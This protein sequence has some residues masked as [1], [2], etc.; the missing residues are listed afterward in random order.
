MS[1]RAPLL[2]HEVQPFRLTRV[3]LMVAIPPA[4]MTL[5]LIWQVVLGHPWGRQPMSNA[6]VIGWTIFLWLVYFR[7]MT[8]RLVT[9]VSAA[10]VRVGMRG[11]WRERRVPLGEIQETKIVTFDAARDWGGYG[12]RTNRRGTAYIA[13]GNRG[14]MLMVKKGAPIFIGSQR[15]EEMI[16]AI[17]HR[18][19]SG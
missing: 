10:Q 1:R 4:L 17:N 6:S 5:L 16:S 7:L 13:G 19:T 9:D 12:I 14:V 11:L 3:R 2:F 8:V 18:G 15:P